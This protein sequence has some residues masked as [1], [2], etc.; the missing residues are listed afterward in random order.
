LRGQLTDTSG[1]LTELGKTAQ[2]FKIN[3]KSVADI[4][5]MD[6]TTF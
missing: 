6:A 2:A 5:N 3:G 1:K 4:I